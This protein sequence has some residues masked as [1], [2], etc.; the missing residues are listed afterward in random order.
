[1]LIKSSVKTSYQEKLISAGVISKTECDES[2]KSYRLAIEKGNSVVHN[3][4]TKPNESMWFDWT[5]YM[6]QKEM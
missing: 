4:A 2:E 6:N 3:L 5:P 1:L